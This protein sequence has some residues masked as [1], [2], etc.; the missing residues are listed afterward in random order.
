[1]AMLVKKQD[2]KPVRF[3]EIEDKIESYINSHDTNEKVIEVGEDYLLTISD[4]VIYVKELNLIMAQMTYLNKVDNKGGYMADFAGTA[5]FKLEKERFVLDY[6]ES[7]GF[8]VTAYNYGNYTME[9]IYAATAVMFPGTNFAKTV[10]RENVRE[11]V[12]ETS[13]E[14]ELEA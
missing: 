6:F 10:Y 1:M 8:L 12:Y 4:P 5:I 13:Y 2:V 9:Q 11:H 3:V 14:L 7:D